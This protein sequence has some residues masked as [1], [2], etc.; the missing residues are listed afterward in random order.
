MRG[1]GDFLAPP[2]QIEI[3][4]V[5]AFSPTKWHAADKRRGRDFLY[6]RTVDTIAAGKTAIFDPQGCLML[7]KID[8][9]WRA[10]SESA[11]FVCASE[12]GPNSHAHRIDY[13][14]IINHGLLD[15]TLGLNGMT[16]CCFGRCGV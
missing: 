9:L 10:R 6:T 1:G 14:Y 2:S 16:N 5:I 4:R 8:F 11:E 7:R 3:R 12:E 13:R 15:L